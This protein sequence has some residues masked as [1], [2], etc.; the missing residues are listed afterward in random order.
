MSAAEYSPRSDG[1]LWPALGDAL[2]RR[3]RRAGVADDDSLGRL[4]D[5]CVEPFV[6][7]AGEDIIREDFP[8]KHVL[9]L[10]QGWAHRYKQL[11]EGRRQTTGFVFPGELCDVDGLALDTIDVTVSAYSRCV[12][13][14]IPRQA[15][16]DLLDRD[17]GLRA[18]FRWLAVI[19]NAIAGEWTAS[20]GR[21]SA[22]ERVAHLICESLLRM[23]ISPRSGPMSFDFP[24]TQADLAD[25]AGVSV[26]HVNRVLKGLRA[27]RLVEVTRRQVT[28]LDWEATKRAGG[29]D[30]A[31]LRLTPQGR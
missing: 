1:A 19:D 20:L 15:L 14:R 27:A 8:V 26:V 23:G 31:Y 18:A 11:S 25:V 13:S 24:L 29:F 17:A 6:V 9:L 10:Q 4:N 3:L 22:E 21:R 16:L 5:I 7:A 28:I 2:T 30:G 12:L